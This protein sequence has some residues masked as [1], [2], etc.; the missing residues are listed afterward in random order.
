MGAATPTSWKIHLAVLFGNGPLPATNAEALAHGFVEELHSCGTIPPHC[1]QGVGGVEHGC[2]VT[3]RHILA[4]RGSNL[5]PLTSQQCQQILKEHKAALVVVL[6]TNKYVSINDPRQWACAF[7]IT[8]AHHVG[9]QI[10]RLEEHTLPTSWFADDGHVGATAGFGQHFGVLAAPSPKV[11]RTAKPGAKPGVKPDGRRVKPAN[12][13]TLKKY[14]PYQFYS[15]ES[16]GF[17]GFTRLPTGFT[18]GVTV[19]F[20]VLGTLG[21]LPC[22]V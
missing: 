1:Q 3:M 15:L 6:L 10:Q 13:M 21:D 22:R 4:V 20:T 7:G 8:L 11:P 17:A 16:F 9:N 14:Y 12:P 5:H 2:C 19:G 18:R